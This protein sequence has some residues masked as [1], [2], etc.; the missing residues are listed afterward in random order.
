MQIRSGPA[1]SHQGLSLAQPKAQ[2]D[3]VISGAKIVQNSTIFVQIG[4]G[5]VK[6]HQGLSL[7]QPKAHSDWVILSARIV[8]KSTIFVQIGSGP[9]KGHQGLSPAQPKAQSHWLISNQGWPRS[10]PRM[11][12]QRPTGHSHEILDQSH[13]IPIGS[14]HAM[15]AHVHGP[16]RFSAIFHRPKR[17]LGIFHWPNSGRAK[18]GPRREASWSKA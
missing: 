7:A 3:W 13:E 11:A 12:G 15:L 9:A 1:K 10:G 16:V 14:S 5:P 8:Q 6:R 17:F 4:L 2:S 18:H